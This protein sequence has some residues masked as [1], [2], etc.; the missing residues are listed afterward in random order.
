MWTY[1][2]SGGSTASFTAPGRSTTTGFIQ[3][4][5]E[6]LQRDAAVT[7]AVLVNGIELRGRL[8]ELPDQEQGIVAEAVRAARRACNLA[9]PQTFGDE[10]IP[11]FGIFH[12]HHDTDV[13]CASTVGKICQQLAVVPPVPFFPVTFPAG[14]VGGMHARSATQRV[15]AQAGVVGQRRQAR[16]AAGVAR[17]G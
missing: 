16:G 6:L 7:D 4:G 8:A 9:V 1:S 12:Q 5:D 17:L 14:V 10:R 13:V 11:V 3:Q 2:A 15:D